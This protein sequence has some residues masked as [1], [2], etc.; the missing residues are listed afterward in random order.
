MAES[1]RGKELSAG[2]TKQIVLKAFS[3]LAAG[4]GLTSTNKTLVTHG[5]SSLP[6]VASVAGGPI[7][8]FNTFTGGTGDTEVQYSFSEK[9]IQYR[10]IYV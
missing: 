5:T 3:V 9:C 8:P 6:P 2:H 7:T 4:A 10:R 1:Q